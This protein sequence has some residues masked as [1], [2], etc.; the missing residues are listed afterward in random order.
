[1]EFKYGSP[2]PADA[3]GVESQVQLY[4]ALAQNQEPHR[5]EN[6]LN[7]ND[8]LAAE[9]MSPIHK[10]IAS[11]GHYTFDGGL[12][13]IEPSH[14]PVTGLT[15]IKTRG[16]YYSRLYEVIGWNP[17][18]VRMVAKVEIVVH[19]YPNNSVLKAKAHVNGDTVISE[20][21][22][23]NWWWNTPGYLR[24]NHPST[25][26][27]LDRMAADVVDVLRLHVGRLS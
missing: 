27:V 5:M 16:T 2:V 6:V 14:Y 17:A 22:S 4:V 8:R 1:M 26:G 20:I 9:A 21:P 19:Q 24:G 23:E 10:V 3:A 12:S 18:D 13:P 25:F 15:A 11:S 7:I